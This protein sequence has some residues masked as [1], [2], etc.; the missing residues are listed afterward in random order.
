MNPN[1]SWIDRSFLKEFFLKPLCYAVVLV[2][3]LFALNKFTYFNFSL[4]S[5][6]SFNSFEV[7]GTG[8]VSA[9]P[10]IATTTYTIT[11]SADTEEAARSAANKKQNQALTKLKALGIE[12]KDITSNIYINPNYEATPLSANTVEPAQDSL[13]FPPRQPVQ[14]GYVANVTTEI[15]SSDVEK[16]NQAID[17]VTAIGATV[18]GVSYTFD[19]QEKYKMEATDK[20]I[21]HAKQ[22]AENMAQA[23]G[24]KLGKI[25]SIRN[26]DDGYGYPQPYSADAT[27][28][29]TVPETQTDLQPGENEITARIG[30]TYYILD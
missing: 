6:N 15:K 30:V 9:V 26:A 23:A 17:V 8:K 29:A 11:E 10:N 12:Q 25:V 21:A 16:I 3:V 13:I 14:N 24:F 20:A 18:G 19:D 28:K 22:Q 4:G 27:L 2:L 7:I 5:N 1:T